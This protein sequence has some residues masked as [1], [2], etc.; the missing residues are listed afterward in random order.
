METESPTGIVFNVQRYTIHDGP[1]IRTELFLKGCPLRCKWCGNPE[2]HKPYMQAGIYPSKCLGLEA[3][4][5]CAKSCAHDALHFDSGK[6]SAIDREACR[7]CLECASACPS[8]AIKQWGTPM[9]AEEAAEVV[10]RDISYYN[11]S[12]GG[13]TL[14]GGEP[15]MQAD[16][17][18]AL[19]SICREE[20]IQTCME[21][22]LCM[23]WDVISKVLPVT[24]M[25]ISDIKHM[26]TE[27]HRAYT[28]AGNELILE[29][30][31]KVVRTGKPV[32]LRV[33]VIPDVNDTPEN[34]EATADFILG[35]LEGKIKQL[36]LLEF[37]RL[38]EE[39]YE[40]LCIPYPM[41]G[42]Q[43]DKDKFSTKVK[44]FAEYFNSRGIPCIAGA[45][46]KEE[47]KHD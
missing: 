43:V 21:T 33:P 39:K 15:L 17:A 28:G 42:I 18:A 19:F 45:T 4:G 22:T 5:L 20:G 13:V 12:G 16:F 27:T 47:K 34:M 23:G 41:A 11:S 9:T 10:R 32:I 8:D 29:N 44:G 3:C 38:G 35:K 30:I 36:Q 24:D 31:E 25:F 2:S 1:G 14:S 26:D 6:L 40:S 46:T 7:N 37:M